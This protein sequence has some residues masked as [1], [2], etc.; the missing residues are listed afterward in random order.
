[1]LSLKQIAASMQ[2]TEEKIALFL[3]E[4]PPIEEIREP[5]ANIVESF[6]FGALTKEQAL[7][8][9]LNANNRQHITKYIVE[10]NLIL[11]QIADSN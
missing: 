4:T 9:I 11:E 7:S 2:D 3:L 5:I 6:R 8:K 1:M 10:Q